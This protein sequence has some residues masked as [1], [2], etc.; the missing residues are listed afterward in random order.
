MAVIVCTYAQIKLI[1]K[2]ELRMLDSTHSTY[3]YGH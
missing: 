3:F 2:A 1:Y